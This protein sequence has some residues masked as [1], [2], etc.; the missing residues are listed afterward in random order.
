MEE[1]KSLWTDKKRPIFGWPIS[2]TR[3]TLYED[4]LYKRIQILSVKEEEIR[5]YRIMDITL[6]MTLFDRLFGVGSI[7]CHSADVTSP[8]LEIKKV[9]N[10]EKV[11]SML[12][13]LIEK[14]RISNGVTMGEFIS[15]MRRK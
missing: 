8:V 6:Q 14:E 1:R 2:F 10:V 3:Y 11:R 12:S 13:E 15:P 7:I 5:L 4:K 9:K